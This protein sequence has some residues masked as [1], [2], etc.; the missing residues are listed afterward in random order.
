MTSYE[1]I[2]E[3]TSHSFI[4]SNIFCLTLIEK[5]GKAIYLM[6]QRSKLAR[7]KKE[8]KKYL[9]IRRISDGWEQK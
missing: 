7:V 5:P 3:L 1:W 9:V 4:S 8:L 6:K 2:H